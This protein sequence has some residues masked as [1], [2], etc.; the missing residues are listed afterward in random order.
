MSEE[1][2]LISCICV[3]RGKPRMLERSIRC[4]R[5]QTYPT[6]ELIILFELDDDDTRQFVDTMSTH[7]DIRVFPVERH[8]EVKLGQLRNLAIQK[9]NGEYICQWDDDD[10]YHIGRLEYQYAVI[11]GSESAGCIIR[12]WLVFDATTGKGYISN[13]RLWEG[14][15]LCQKKELE[16]YGYENKSAGEDCAPIISLF[17]AEKLCPITDVHHL[18]I[19]IYHGK[20]TFHHP[21]WDLI[22]Q[23]SSL[24]PDPINTEIK[25]IL[26]QEYTPSEGSFLLDKLFDNH[27]FE[28]E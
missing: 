23:A 18:Y 2:P 10:W 27:I 26:A 14:S 24:L 4:F 3:T 19:Y 9:A 11:A 22:F 13:S 8:P 21:H 15:V 20:N 5:E 6:K 28:T 16:K 12:E 1:Y 25:K 17:K 7:P